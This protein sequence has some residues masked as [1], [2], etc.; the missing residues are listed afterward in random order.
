MELYYCTICGLRVSD[1]EIQDGNAVI[2]TEKRVLCKKCFSDVRGA[3]P[4]T[5][6]VGSARVAVA[7]SPQAAAISAQGPLASRAH[8]PSATKA[9]K[10]VQPT[11]LWVGIAGALAI[12]V[13]AIVGSRRTSVA[14]DVPKEI[15]KI[16]TAA[17]QPGAAI[18]AETKTVAAAPTPA[19]PKFSSSFKAVPIRSK[20]NSRGYWEFLPSAYYAN[21][22][23]T[24]PIV[25]YFCNA[26]ESGDGS[27]Q[28][29]EKLRTCG[30]S[31]LLSES[32]HPLHNLFEERGVIIL[33]V[34]GP[35]APDWWHGVY[36]E[37]VLTEVLRSYRIDSRRIYLTGMVAGALGLHELMDQHGTA[38]KQA[39]AIWMGC[40]QGGAGLLGEP[41]TGPEIASKI[42]YW[43]FVNQKDSNET[44]RG[45]DNIAAKVAGKPVPSV[46]DNAPTGRAQTAC[47]S[48]ATGW[49][50]KNGVVDPGSSNPVLTLTNMSP[51]ETWTLAYDSMEC[52]NWLLA[53]KK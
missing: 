22:A 15:S 14:A 23:Q 41:K 6:R 30:P 44:A 16:S 29:L 25:I 26:A 43:A 50:W 5:P 51:A 42:P 12:L 24:F 13:L 19:A 1:S 33:A 21:P 34:Q 39:A 20:G 9:K 4:T 7:P 10:P 52:W 8:H 46:L 36:I 49:A 53:Q 47:Y 11:M 48:N 27:A 3:K 28:Q 18:P 31:K 32:T 40:S 35:P 37:P 38:A 2:S 45:V 17:K